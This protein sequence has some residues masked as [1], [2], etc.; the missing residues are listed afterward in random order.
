MDLV[1][2]LGIAGFA[3]IAI[4]I[5]LLGALL[6]VQNRIRARREDAELAAD[7]QSAADIVSKPPMAIRRPASRP[8]MAISGT[9]AKAFSGQAKSLSGDDGTPPTGPDGKP[10]NPWEVHARK[11]EAAKIGF[12]SSRGSALIPIIHHDYD[13]YVDHDTAVDVIDTLRKAGPDAPVDLILHTPGGIS[14]ATQQILHALK[15]H[16]GTKTAF[17]PYRAKSAGT[18]IALACD[19][20]VMGPNAVLGPIDP[21]YGWM[22]A[23]YLAEL[24]KSKSADRVDDEMII[25]S[26]MAKQA[27]TEARQFA[28]DYV[29]DA[30]KHKGTCTFT[31]DL[32]IG[33]RN[34]DYPILPGEAKDDFR[35][36][37]STN[38]PEA[39]YDICQPPPKLDPVM[40]VSMFKENGVEH[41]EAERSARTHK[42]RRSADRDLF[43]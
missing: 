22:P 23:Q 21:Q 28:C 43:R 1:T 25:L 36:H 16:R 10:A 7:F 8:A 2:N 41:A 4:I 30:H 11:V 39:P 15:E 9:E 6:V 20:I 42:P 40:I 5:V 13:E 19:E 29:N 17:V 27:M 31:E 3:G 32:I 26:K 34:H 38:M 37:V 33:G 14:S 35:L 12:A 24:T 18:M